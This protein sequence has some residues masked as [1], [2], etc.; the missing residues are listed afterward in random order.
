SGMLLISYMLYFSNL[1]YKLESKANKLLLFFFVVI[2][3]GLI[4]FKE[5]YIVYP[6]LGNYKYIPFK[7]YPF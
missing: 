6:L 5:L 2:Y 4:F 1:L 7:I 3:S